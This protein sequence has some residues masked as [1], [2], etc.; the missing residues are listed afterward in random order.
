MN[1][2]VVILGNKLVFELADV[3]VKNIHKDHFPNVGDKQKIE[4]AIS[5]ADL[6][7]LE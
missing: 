5:G 6:L 3:S 4:V 1:Y 2:V 7:D